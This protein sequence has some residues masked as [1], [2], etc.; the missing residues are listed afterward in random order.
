M[1]KS[2]IFLISAVAAFILSFSC[3]KDNGLEQEPETPEVPEE[4]LPVISMS[5]TKNNVNLYELIDFSMS[6]DDYDKNNLFTGMYALSSYDSLVWHIDGLMDHVSK[7]GRVLLGV[8]KSFTKPG[9]YKGCITGYRDGTGYPGNTV[10]INVYMSGDFLSVKWDDPRPDD[11]FNSMNDKYT[12]TLKYQDSPCTYASLDFHSGWYSWN[13][14]EWERNHRESRI[15]LKDYITDLYGEPSFCFDGEDIAESEL[16]EVY[17][18]RFDLPL[19][20]TDWIED[21]PVAIW[22]SP[23]AHIALTGMIFSYSTEMQFHIVA[24]PRKF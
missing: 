21:V 8:G 12:L 4:T 11:Y 14:E 2:P 6:V 5:A 17:A 10:A 9:N 20:K 23:R 22:D 7:D 15:L 1:K 18:E 19:G 3:S 13:D 24:E 16:G